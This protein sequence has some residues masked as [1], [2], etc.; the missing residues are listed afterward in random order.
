MVLPII[1][2][3]LTSVVLLAAN[4]LRTAAEIVNASD[5]AMRV[6]QGDRDATVLDAF[7]F[8]GERL[9]VVRGYTGPVSAIW[10]PGLGGIAG[11]AQVT[12]VEET[13]STRLPLS[14][15]RLGDI[16]TGATRSSRVAGGSE[17]SFFVRPDTDE[18]CVIL[19]TEVRVTLAR[20]ADTN[21]F[22]SLLVVEKI[23]ADGADVMY[24]AGDN[25]RTGSKIAQDTFSKLVYVLKI[26]DG[27]LT[28]CR[29]TGEGRIDTLNSTMLIDTH[30][31]NP[32][33]TPILEA[34]KPGDVLYLFSKS[35]AAEDQASITANYILQKY[36]AE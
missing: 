34:A 21:G 10:E 29:S 17:W 18:Y 4:P 20:P 32:D 13:V 27:Q 33:G 19:G 6:V 9:S 35:R 1:T 7:V 25:W 2:A 3:S 11:G 31:D 5:R 36:D 24:F 12:E 22:C 23:D 8:P 28:N 30:R 26:E 16:R 14:N 15:V